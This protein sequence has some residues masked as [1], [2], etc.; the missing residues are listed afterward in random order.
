MK[1]KNEFII[2]KLFFNIISLKNN[3]LFQRCASAII[4]SL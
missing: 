2:S 1:K 4:P 3:N